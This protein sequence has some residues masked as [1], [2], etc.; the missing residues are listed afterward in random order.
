MFLAEAYLKVDGVVINTT[1]EV[2]GHSPQ[3][4]P[5]F[6]YQLQGRGVSKTTLGLSNSLE[7]CT[8]GHNDCGYALLQWKNKGY[9]LN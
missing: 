8:E 6:W 2:R 3:E 7:E 5:H 1:C 4:C 9:W